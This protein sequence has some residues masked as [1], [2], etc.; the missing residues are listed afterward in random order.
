MPTQRPTTSAPATTHL[1]RMAGAFYLAEILTH[2]P[3]VL[4][5]GHLVS[6]SN[7]AVTAEN[8]LAHP[9]LLYMAF[10]TDLLGFACYVTV[11]ALLYQLFKPVNRN[12]SLTAACFS[13]AGCT[14]GALSCAFTLVPLYLLQGSSYSAAFSRAQLQGLAQFL[15]R[16]YSQSFNT[17]FVLFGFY[18]VLIGYLAFR[19][20]FLPRAVGVLMAIAGLGWLTFLYPPAARYLSP[21]ILVPG[22]IGEGSLTLW[23][24]TG[25]LRQTGFAPPT[26]HEIS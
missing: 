22:I 14:I 21:A 19:S 1:A 15:F 26:V 16:V 18:C 24:L 17:S 9:Q 12:A 23:L 10:A 5:R 20:Q 3:G 7:P 8:I 11:T 6:P 13:L 4:I 25:R 2:I